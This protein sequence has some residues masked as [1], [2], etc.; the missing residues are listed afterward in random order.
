[1]L[2]FLKQRIEQYQPED[3]GHPS[4]EFLRQMITIMQE[5]RDDEQVTSHDDRPPEQTVCT[6]EGVHR[7]AE[8]PARAPC[9]AEDQGAD[10]SEDRQ[11]PANAKHAVH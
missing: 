2:R 5:I 9:P 1:V 8:P 3:C 11:A 7:P 4:T 10:R 6:P